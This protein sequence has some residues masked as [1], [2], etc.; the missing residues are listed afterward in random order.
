MVPV[1]LPRGMH[2]S[3]RKQWL[4]Q[5]V[6]SPDGTRPGE[7]A[8]G[9]A[10]LEEKLG[11]TGVVALDENLPPESL[12]QD[13]DLPWQHADRI[14]TY[15]LAEALAQEK[16]DRIEEQRPSIRKLGRNGVKSLVLR[17][18]ESI[19][20]DMGQD[21]TVAAEFGLDKATFSPFAGSRWRSGGTI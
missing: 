7:E 19:G 21:G 3:S 2:G 15:G 9:Q 17:V 11:S 12:M 4:K 18:F 1:L 10:I 5:N 6:P 13:S 20:N 14:S 8:R 16:A